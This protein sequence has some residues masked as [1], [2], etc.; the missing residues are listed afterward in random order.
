MRAAQPNN[1]DYN[2]NRKIKMPDQKLLSRQVKK[3]FGEN[4][5]PDA[6]L[7]QFINMVRQSYDGFERDRELSEHSFSLAEGDYNRIN[8]QLK[9]EFDLK[10]ESVNALKS[11]IFKLEHLDSD[12]AD[13]LNTLED[14][15]LLGII[16]FLNGQIAKRR[17][18][19]TELIKAKEDAEAASNAKS[20]FLSMMSH[21]IRTPLNA[22]IGISYLMIEEREHKNL[23]ENLN[24]LKGSAENLHMLIN[25]ILDF[26]KLEAGK[27]ILEKRKF[28]LKQSISKLVKTLRPKADERRNRIH[29]F[30]QEDLHENFSGDVTRLNQVMNNLLGNA[31]KFTENGDITVMI[32]GAAISA[33]S[34]QLKISVKDTGIGISPDKQQVIFESFTQ[35]NNSISRQFGG[36]GLG[37]AII[38]KILKLFNSDIK[39]ISEAGK[40]S[41][42]YFSIILDS[43]DQSKEDLPVAISKGEYTLKGLRILLVEDNM[44]N[45]VIATK[46]LEGWDTHVEVVY[47]GLEAVNAADPAKYDVVLMDLQ[48]PVMDGY[49]ATIDITKRFPQLPVIALTASALYEINEKTMSCGF[50]DF[51]SKPINPFELFDKLNKYQKVK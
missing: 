35:A 46:F 8:Q 12:K 22:I 20:E 29:F 17:L 24:L 4:F 7:E 39:V 2:F 28:N 13:F 5:E 43:E 9:E 11:A 42:F 38:R 23:A 21:E 27:L 26:N 41:E 1:D 34:Y 44:M 31:I 3:A 49:T 19:E 25:D 6:K 10:H 32:M 15:N 37:L 47:N 50:S 45:I 16:D 40:G 14:D 18:A 51:V 48:M 33:T 30:Y 36:S